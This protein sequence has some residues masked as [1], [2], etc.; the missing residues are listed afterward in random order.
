MIL[1]FLYFFA[2]IQQDG[3]SLE[4]DAYLYGLVFS[5]ACFLFMIY[6]FLIVNRDRKSLINKLKGRNIPDVF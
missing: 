6:A 3:V 5:L 2:P 1:S 4:I